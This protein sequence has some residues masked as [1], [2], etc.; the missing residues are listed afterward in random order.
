MRRKKT[1]YLYSLSSFIEVLED[2]MFPKLL[3]PQWTTAIGNPF[4]KL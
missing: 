2:Q 1:I 3:K 4:H